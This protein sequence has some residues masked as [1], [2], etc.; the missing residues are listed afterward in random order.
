MSTAAIQR[1]RFLHR[2]R[3]ALAK[4]PGEG[5]PA[6]RIEQRVVV[7]LAIALAAS[8]W[9]RSAAADDAPDVQALEEQAI[10]AAVAR[11][12]NSVV[13]IETVGGLERVG[14]LTVGT[15]PTTGLVVSPDGHIVS[16]AFNFIQQPTT[17]LVT[18]PGES[19]RVPARIVAR[20][21]SRMLVL[22]KVDA[23]KKLTVPKT[24]PRDQMVVGQWSI[25]VGR[26]YSADQVSLSSG[27]ISATS[28]IWGKAIQ[29][30]AKVSPANYGGPLVDIQ[31]RVLGI[32][33]PLSP[34]STGAVAGAEWYDSGIGFA[35]PV[36]EI[37]DK[38]PRWIEGDLKPGLL[39][40]SL[41]GTDIYALPADVGSVRVKSPAYEAG[42]RAGDRI[43]EINGKSIDRQAQLKH[44]LGPLYAGDEVKVAV[45]RKGKRLD[46]TATLTD[47]LVP[48]E[49]PYLGVLP[50]R[51][52]DAFVVRHVAPDSPAEKAGLQAGDR[53]TGLDGE[54]IKSTQDAR[55]H[56][57]NLEANDSLQ[58]AFSRNDES[59]EIKATLA[60]LPEAVPAELPPLAP[61]GEAPDVEAATGVVEIKIPEAKN[62]CL[63][64]IPDNYR[65]DVPHGVLIW[66]H[67][68]NKFDQDG[69]F[70]QWKT[71]C[72]QRQLILVAPQSA[73]P[74]RWTPT[75]VEFVVKTLEDILGRYNIDRER[76]VMGGLQAGGSLAYLAAFQ[77]R[78]LIRGVVAVDAGIPRST[79]MPQSDPLQRL[80][81]YATRAAESRVAAA[82][83][84]GAAALR[85]EK[86]PVT[87]H[88]HAGK[89][90]PLNAEEVEEVGRWIDSLDRL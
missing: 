67:A 90:R 70:K 39:G 37:L 12:S 54:P 27:V 25:A 44:A 26:T 88:E 18:L 71:V 63:A 89:G 62:Q 55:E 87:I 13:R 1:L 6:A 66:L 57:A 77:Q 21:A 8:S 32:L 29:T 5:R 4:A 34:Q 50:D 49:T 28:R 30:D 23:D 80:A 82:V 33:V 19:R 10:K 65:G 81:I 43:V 85:K 7:A 64:L 51:L 22:L 38:L 68:P 78:E 74:K 58:I 84:A 42:I 17:I 36:H 40:I 20:D 14:R 15:G 31:G 24:V 45:V 46:M 75:E 59:S 76:V 52:N 11:A 35:I 86:L 9:G 79:A 61:E 48:Y 41:K 69:L 72:Q 73:D 47:V 56:F 16:S 83:K 53:I 60:A 2:R 3:Q